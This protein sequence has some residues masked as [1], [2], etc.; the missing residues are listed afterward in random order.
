MQTDK[1][2][3]LGQLLTV[4]IAD[5]WADSEDSQRVTHNLRGTLNPC[6]AHAM[7]G[8]DNPKVT[9][10]FVEI[11]DI[12]E[13][14]SNEQWSSFWLGFYHRKRGPGRPPGTTKPDS[15]K[16]RDRHITITDEAWGHAQKQGNASG[17]IEGLI[18]KDKPGSK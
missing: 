14:L 12:P 13:A 6:L 11:G 10:L 8:G 3:V 5:G 18:L 7:Q 9:G 2:Y 4:L 17:Y 15:D 16:R 1:A